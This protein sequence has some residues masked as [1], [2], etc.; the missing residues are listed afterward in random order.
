MTLRVGLLCV[1]V[2]PTLDVAFAGCDTMTEFCYDANGNLHAHGTFRC[3][4]CG[5]SFEITGDD[6]K[7][8]PSEGRIQTVIG[9]DGQKHF[10]P[11]CDDCLDD[12]ASDALNGVL[13][14]MSC[15]KEAVPQSYEERMTAERDRQASAVRILAEFGIPED[16][17]RRWQS[18]SH[19]DTGSVVTLI[20]LI[21]EIIMVGTMLSASRSKKKDV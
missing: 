17:I 9:E 20:S 5:E 12:L 14:D 15:F 6:F 3:A 10:Y 8:R 21:P 1:I 18:A 11:I 19:D 13:P 7:Q 2:F 4:R 16:V